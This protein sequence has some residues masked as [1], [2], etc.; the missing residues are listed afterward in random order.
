MLKSFFISLGVVVLL[1][2]TSCGGESSKEAK[3]LLSK[4]LQFIGIPHSIIVNV[5]QDSNRDGIC[6]AKE[7]FTK[8]TIKKGESIDDIYE[9]IALTSDGRY[10]LRNVD[11]NIPILV[12]IE[13][14]KNIQYDGGKLTLKFNGF[15]TDNQNETKEISTIQL[16]MDLGYL[17]VQE[18]QALK[19]TPNREVID[20]AIF[21]SL[22]NNYNLLRDESLNSKIARDKGLEVLANEL[23]KVDIANELPKQIVL[24]EDNASCI[25]SSVTTTSQELNITKE[26]AE[27]I[28]QEVKRESRHIADGYVIKLQS[29]IEAQCGGGVFYQSN[30]NMGAKGE[31][32]FSDADLSDNCKLIVPSDAIIDSNNNG[33]YDNSDKTVGFIMKGDAD[34]TFITPLTTLLL[35]K[36]VKGEDTKVFKEMVQHYNPVS[37]AS[38]VGFYTGEKK[39]QVQKL[40]ILTEVLKIA[41]K[42]GAD[43]SVIDLT[44]IL[45][46]INFKDMDMGRLMGGLSGDIQNRIFDA[47]KASG[48]QN[49][50]GLLDKFDTSKVNLN[51]LMVNI[52]DGGKSLNDAIREA[53][54]I[55]LSPDG[56]PID[57]VVKPDVDVGKSF[58][59]ITEPTPTPV[60]TNQSPIA[61]AGLD[62]SVTVNESITIRGSASDIDG[63]VIRYEWT[64]KG[65]IVLATMPTFEYIPTRAGIDR[66]TLT[67]TDD[68]GAIDSDYML[69]TVND[70]YSNDGNDPYSNDGND[71][72]NNN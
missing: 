44:Q 54:K 46:N 8:I 60:E 62:K 26:E 12:E 36:K 65:S 2:F 5:C 70:P 28:A 27:I 1:G 69:L 56:N 3:E 22:E 42:E 51:T 19:E 53:T 15:E 20:Y 45:S 67:V 52:S 37:A 6:G 23:K 63:R 43:I 7:L 9:K 10:F 30:L 61:N 48:I 59:D 11:L 21:E 64:K 41:M 40:I 72:Y 47:L 38:A 4:I 33:R 68:D 66:L 24:C 34:G 58:G 18:T 49:L 35:S 29:P 57:E 17:T 25:K 39:N 13:D 71:P 16:L 50:V 32:F 31:V 14:S 55:P